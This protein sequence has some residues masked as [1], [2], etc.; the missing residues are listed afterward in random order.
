M[1]AFALN[2][3]GEK[4]EKELEAEIGN[5]EALSGFLTGEA[6][7]VVVVGGSGIALGGT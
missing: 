1:E 7:I 6:G 3:R 5:P 4:E 2:P